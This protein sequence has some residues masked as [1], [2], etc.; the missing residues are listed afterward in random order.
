MRD[1]GW[2]KGNAPDH[3]FVFSDLHVALTLLV[4]WALGQKSWWHLLKFFTISIIYLFNLL[5][6]AL[7][8]G[9]VL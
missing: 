8:T 1:S 2:G 5:C 6:P 9:V 3:I 4:H 7:G